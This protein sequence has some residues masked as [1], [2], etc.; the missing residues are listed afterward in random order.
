MIGA[1]SFW[2]AL[3][4]SADSHASSAFPCDLTGFF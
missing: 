1:P 2:F 4:I 3:V